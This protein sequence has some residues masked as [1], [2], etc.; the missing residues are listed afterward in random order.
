MMQLALVAL[1]SLAALG[2]IAWLMQQARA[3]G[4]ASEEA[5]QTK[6]TLDAINDFKKV[7]AGVDA[8]PARDVRD[9]LRR[10]KRK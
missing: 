10:W 4:K 9:E 8:M 2:L 7:E 3:G 5:K 6:A 1:G